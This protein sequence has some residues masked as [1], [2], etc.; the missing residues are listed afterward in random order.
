MKN[1]ILLDGAAGS[2]LWALAKE[3]GIEVVPTYQ[4]NITHPELL[5]QM[6][7]EYISAGSE[8]I[9]T[10]TFAVNSLALEESG[11][12]VVEV[13]KAA[14]KI[15]KEVTKDTNVKVY[16]SIGPLT[17]LLEPYGDLSIEKTHTIYKQLV[18]TI[19]QCDIEYV[20]FETFMDLRMLEIAVEEA[21]KVGLKVIASMTF[22]K[23]NRTIMGDKIE[24]IA[25]KL[26]ELNVHAMG[27]NCS[28]GPKEAK[29]VIEEFAKYTKTDLYVKPNSGMDENYDC[30]TFASEM[31]VILPLVKYVGACCGSDASYI[32]ELKKLI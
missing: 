32:S 1:H 13:V 2:R 8:M 3:K 30:C 9:Q 24:N 21:N 27:M 25:A 29:S 4:Y 19:K 12:E 28:M 18:E 5:A 26:D 22:G 10:N 31:K 23:R 14:C 15:A 7:Q 20:F 11:F 6:Y 17:K 16:S